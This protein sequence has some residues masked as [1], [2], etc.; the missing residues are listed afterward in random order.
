M[1]KF[2]QSR[3][4]RS[5][6]FFYKDFFSVQTFMYIVSSSVS[7]NTQEQI[8]EIMLHLFLRQFELVP[9]ALVVFC[10]VTVPGQVVDVACG[11]DHMVALAK[12][13]L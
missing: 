10:Q 3:P 2:Y 13:L 4:Q 7:K 12:S 1:V 9:F 11:V 5:L 6:K 8:Q